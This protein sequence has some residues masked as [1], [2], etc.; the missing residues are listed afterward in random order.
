MADLGKGT[1]ELTLDL[2]LEHC[3]MFT[4]VQCNVNYVHCVVEGPQ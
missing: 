2:P 4:L 1:K 3:H